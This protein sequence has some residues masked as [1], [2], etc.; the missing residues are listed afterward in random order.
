VAEVFGKL[1]YALVV[2]KNTEREVI[3]RRAG[4]FA[5]SEREVFAIRVKFKGN[6][7]AG[8]TFFVKIGSSAVFIHFLLFGCK[9]E[10]INALV[11]FLDTSRAKGYTF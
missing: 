4:G 7:R 1:A 9:S 8:E 2:R 3:S 5:N 6:A 10:K 11:A